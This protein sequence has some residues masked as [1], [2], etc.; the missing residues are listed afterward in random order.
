MPARSSTA[1]ADADD[2]PSTPESACRS[3]LR[4]CWKAASTSANVARRSSSVPGSSPRS[5]P[6]S[7]E[8]TFGTGQNTMRDTWPAV[9]QV[10]YHEAFTLGAP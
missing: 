1:V 8:S 7:T 6:T 9:R 4:R 5:N 2:P 3:I 10:P